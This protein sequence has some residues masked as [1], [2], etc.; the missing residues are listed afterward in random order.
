MY[1]HTYKH[2]YVY[3]YNLLLIIFEKA[4]IKGS[5]LLKLI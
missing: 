5:I 4:M 1:V 3:E 2:M